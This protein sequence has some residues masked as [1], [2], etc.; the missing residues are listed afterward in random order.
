VAAQSDLIVAGLPEGVLVGIILLVLNQAFKAFLWTVRARR[1]HL[2]GV[3]HQTSPDPRGVQEQLRWDQVH[4]HTLGS[5]IWGYVK[6]QEP[7]EEQPKR[8]RFLGR[9]S[10]AQLSGCFWTIDIHSNP[11]SHG[12]FHLQ[13]VDPDTWVGRYTTAVGIRDQSN[14]VTQEL[15]DLPLEWTRQRPRRDAS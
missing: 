14:A 5:W 2:A 3:W 6:R 7:S 15:K 8:W 4:L 11:R 1:R 10:G 12:T 9:I 13:M